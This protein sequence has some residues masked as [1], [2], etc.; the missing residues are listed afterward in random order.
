[1]SQNVT[2]SAAESRRAGVESRH[3]GI[4]PRFTTPFTLVYK[5]SKYPPKPQFSATIRGPQRGLQ[6]GRLVRQHV[7]ASGDRT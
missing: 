1:M 3:V 2:L 6:A 5:C 4:A 7:A